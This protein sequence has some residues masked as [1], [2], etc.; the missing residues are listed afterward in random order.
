MVAKTP[1]VF[2]IGNCTLD[3]FFRLSRFPKP[4][5]TLLASEPLQDI[6]GKGAN[7]AVIAARAGVAVRFVAA[8]GKDADGAEIRANLQREGLS[9]E[10]VQ[11]VEAP[12]DKSIIYVASDSENCIVSSHAA[13]ATLRTEDVA[14]L[15]ASAGKKDFVL[16]QGNLSADLTRYCLETS[17]KQGATTLLNPAPIHYSF[18]PIWP[19][20]NTAI[21]NAVEISALTGITD[22]IA[23]ARRLNATGVERVIVTL[24]AKGVLSLTAAER[25]E[26]PA[27]PVAA[28]D[29][30]GA[31]DVFCGVYVAGL[32]L[33]YDPVASLRVA[34][35]A[36][37]RAVTRPGT[38]S[39]FPSRDELSD[40]IR[41]AR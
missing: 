18:D 19:F 22:P 29:T 36:A 37:A 14:D 7:Q 26:I 15:L 4:G 16:M 28:V 2:V 17:R 34:N 11:Q 40:I 20:V 6:G 25:L 24:G 13:A 39:A 3:L 38:Q 10:H 41:T 33:G 30:T 23:G 1:T 32:A 9:V 21:L 35:E 31:G 27:V 8:V 5:E 12:T